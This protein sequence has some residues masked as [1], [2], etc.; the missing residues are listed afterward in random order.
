VK[1]SNDQIV[2]R[3]SGEMVVGSALGDGKT[4][5]KNMDLTATGDGKKTILTAKG[6]NAKVENIDS[7]GKVS[8]D[9]ETV[10]ASAEGVERNKKK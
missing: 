6:D 3:G 7:K 9:G 1:N 5:N 4:I 2:A 8:G 10:I